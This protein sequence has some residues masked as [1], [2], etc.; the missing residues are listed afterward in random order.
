MSD[1]ALSPHMYAAQVAAA[2]AANEASVNEDLQPRRE[3]LMLWI[4]HLEKMLTS[5]EDP[6]RAY[7]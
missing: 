3:E 1:F 5:L 6:H 7:G 2:A 4:L